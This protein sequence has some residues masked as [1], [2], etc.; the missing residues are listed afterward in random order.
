GGRQQGP[1][2]AA[3]TMPDRGQQAEV[4]DVAARRMLVAGDREAAD[5]L[6]VGLG[7]EDGR[8]RVAAQG[9]EVA[10]LVADAAP[11]VR[12]DEPPL[13]LAADRGAE[14]DERGGVARLGPADGRGHAGTTTPWPPRRGS[15]AA[16]SVPSSR[17]ST[18]A[19]P[20]K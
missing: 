6:G 16:A 15:P 11:A 14:R 10:A 9:A 17:T 1:A 2:D 7:D 4:G 19:A 18:A 3:A 20:P 5:E 8:V 13:G 12:G